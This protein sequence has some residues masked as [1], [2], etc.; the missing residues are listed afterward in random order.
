MSMYILH[1][2][3]DYFVRILDSFKC[4]GNKFS[5]NPYAM[6]LQ[7][8]S[9]ENVSNI[10]DDGVFDELGSE[11]IGKIFS[12][13]NPES[14]FKGKFHIS[15]D[16]AVIYQSLI[17]IFSKQ[18]DGS[19]FLE[20]ITLIKNGMAIRLFTIFDGQK[21]QAADGLV[22][23]NLVIAIES[24]TPAVDRFLSAFQTC[25][26]NVYEERT[27]NYLFKVTKVTIIPKLTKMQKC[28][29]DCKRCY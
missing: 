25:S 18:F 27:Y 26:T 29:M 2:K 14:V 5:S 28:Y 13:E 22:D 11:F 23:R 16:N 6:E 10:Y 8:F 12:S 21:F 7:M 4:R 9:G 3:I 17:N 24:T 1:L 15:L 20:K 19:D